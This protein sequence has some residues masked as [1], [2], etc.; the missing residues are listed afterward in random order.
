MFVVL[1]MLAAACSDSSALSRP[2]PAGLSEGES[3]L[4]P[5]ITAPV[6]T[7][8]PTTPPLPPV[9]PPPP[10]PPPVTVLAVGNLG[11]CNAHSNQVVEAIAASTEII[12]SAGDLLA[13]PGQAASGCSLS[14]LDGQL[15]RVYAVPGDQDLVNDQAGVFYDLIAQTSTDTNAGEGWFITSLGG[16]QLIGLNSR[17]NDAGGC[18]VDSAQYQWLDNV[19]RDQPG[20]CRAVVW[21]DARFTSA[22]REVDAADMGAILGRLDGAGI[23]LVITGSPGNYERLGPVRPSGQLPAEGASGIMHFNIGGGSG[24]GFQNKLQPATQV[25]IDEANGYVRFVFS[26]ASYTWEFVATSD[27]NASPDI[28][29]GTC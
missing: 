12:L 9:P 27:G 2:T 10:P 22:S 25:R 21:H 18:G 4:G 20:E 15:D 3:A 26:A 17:C 19:L 11:R 5:T 16:W 8:L 24:V 23:D 1:A 13:E 14:S 28:G 29:S 7:T 6:S